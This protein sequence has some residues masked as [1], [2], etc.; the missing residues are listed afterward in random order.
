VIVLSTEHFV[1][2]ARETSSHYLG[3]LISPS[4]QGNLISFVKSFLHRCFGPKNFFFLI[5][6]RVFAYLKFLRK[7]IHQS[8]GSFQIQ[9]VFLPFFGR[10]I[11]CD[12]IIALQA[13]IFQCVNKNTDLSLGLISSRYTSIGLFSEA[14]CFK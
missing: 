5:E 12:I 8:H 7:I 10:R 4:S 2:L 11:R 14:A 6:G 3:T 9:C 13:F 1:S